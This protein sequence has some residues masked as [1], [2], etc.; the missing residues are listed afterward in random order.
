MNDEDVML[1]YTIE[2]AYITKKSAESL[3][4][5]NPRKLRKA[6]IQSLASTLLNGGHFDSCLVVNRKKEYHLNIIDGQHRVMAMRIYFEK[7]PDSRIQVA[8]VVYRNLTPAE[9]RDVYRKWNISIKQSTDDFINSYKEEIPMFDRLTTEIPCSIYSGPK[10]LKLKDLI[11]AYIGSK[12]Q[13]YKGAE[14]RTSYDFVK[15]MQQL[16]ESD[17]D[18]M[19][20]YFQILHEIF[21][22][23]NT[24][25]FHK[26]SAF[27]NTVFRALCYLVANNIG[28]LGESYVKRRMKTILAN[29]AILDQYRRFYGRRSSVDAYLAFKN[30]LNATQSDKKFV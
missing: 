16:T 22:P 19:K 7:Y 13:P 3:E 15:Y 6:Q 14:S 12:E 8:L 28:P 11:N 20:H 27:K 2:M 25:D 29:R 5:I 23:N 10:T 4:I 18:Q 26:L 9:E 1:D 30:L 24:K 17:V 21:N